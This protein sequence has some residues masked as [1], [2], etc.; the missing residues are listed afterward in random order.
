MKSRLS[1]KI[2]VTNSDVRKDMINDLFDFHNE[3][4]GDFYNA[5]DS[6]LS[7]IEIEINK[8]IGSEPGIKLFNAHAIIRILKGNRILP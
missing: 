7:E 4:E 3:N 1:S 5:L 6:F 8:Q 2:D